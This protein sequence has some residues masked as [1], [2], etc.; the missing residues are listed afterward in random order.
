MYTL[1]TLHTLCT[2]LFNLNFVHI[3]DFYNFFPAKYTN[4]FVNRYKKYDHLSIFRF[5]MIFI[6]KN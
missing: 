3:V 2:R 4:T 5:Q 1:Y 6:A